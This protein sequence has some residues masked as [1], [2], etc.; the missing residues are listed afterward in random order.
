TAVQPALRVND[1]ECLDVARSAGCGVCGA[2]RWHPTAHAPW[3]PRR[4]GPRGEPERLA[5][6]RD[7][8]RMAR[9]T[10]ANAAIDRAAV[11]AACG[12][13]AESIDRCRVSGAVCPRA[14]GDA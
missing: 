4:L 9:A 14:G 5:P 2:G 6:P 11:G 7:C 8:P 10:S 3:G 13:G 1:M 12:G